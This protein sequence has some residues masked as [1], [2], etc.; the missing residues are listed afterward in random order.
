MLA[1]ARNLSW[2]TERNDTNNSYK[3]TQ[4]DDYMNKFLLT[5]IISLSIL[6]GVCVFFFSS[7]Y[8]STCCS[9]GSI[10]SAYVLNLRCNR[11]NL[12]FF[13]F[14]LLLLLILFF[15][16]YS[17][18]LSLSTW[19]FRLSNSSFIYCRVLSLILVYFVSI[20]W[21]VFLLR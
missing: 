6:V 3:R 1:Q 17:L 21:L 14:Y 13:L 8:F 19:S 11:I 20:T 10:F 5:F 4:N 9:P 18:F 12:L 15:L 2:N 16:F 7:F